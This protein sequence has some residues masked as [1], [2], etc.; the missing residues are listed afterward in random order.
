MFLASSRNHSFI[1]RLLRGVFRGPPGPSGLPQNDRLE[2]LRKGLSRSAESSP[3]IH[4]LKFEVCLFARSACFS[5]FHSWF[6]SSETRIYREFQP[7][8][9]SCR[10]RR[11]DKIGRLFAHRFVVRPATGIVSIPRSFPILPANDGHGVSLSKSFSI[12]GSGREL[13]LAFFRRWPP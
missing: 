6:F 7:L 13:R 9:V 12:A 3:S 4:C 2:Q 8:V 10:R 1:E 11:L 5:V